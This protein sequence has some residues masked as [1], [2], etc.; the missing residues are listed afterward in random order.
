MSDRDRQPADLQTPV[1]PPATAGGTGG[2]PYIVAV[3]FVV[4]LAVG[5]FAM[6]IPVL[7]AP[8]EARAPEAGI[9]SIA[10]KPVPVVP[11]DPAAPA[12]PRP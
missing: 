1:V 9:D 11:D 10:G 4:V 3:L 12:Q 8:D 5:Y 7:K 2:L 6:G